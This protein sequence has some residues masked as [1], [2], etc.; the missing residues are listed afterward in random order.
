MAIFEISEKLIT[1]L[2]VSE[3]REKPWHLKEIKNANAAPAHC[4]L[5]MKSQFASL[6]SATGCNFVRYYSRALDNWVLRSCTENE[7]I[8]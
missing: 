5:D 4:P 8:K 2:T 7:G 3:R 6:C 1:D